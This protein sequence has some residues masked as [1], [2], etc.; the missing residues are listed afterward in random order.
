MTDWNNLA[1][2]PTIR[3]QDKKFRLWT[4]RRDRYAEMEKQPLRIVAHMVTPIIHAERDLTHLDSILSFAAL[5]NH[6]VESLHGPSG[7]SVIPLPLELLWVSPKG[8]P[9]WACTPLTPV[10]AAIE[11]KEYWHKRYPTHRAEFGSKMN[12]V[13][14]AGRWKEYRTPV[15]AQQ[16]D[17]LEAFCIGNADEIRRLLDVVTHVGKKGSM[18]YG[19]A[20]KWS[21]D[22]IDTGIDQILSARPVPIE[23]YE[24]KPV[25]GTVRL[26]RGF[27]P[28]YWYVPWW[29]DCVCP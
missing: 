7:V 21:V 15:M 29:A 9:L 13:T 12:A 28:P 18:G 16:V 6:P 22:A 24:P 20:A 26:N 3:W 8:L 27:T 17:L 19:R 11:S 10:G 4:T 5:T 14:S 1:P 23:Y 25:T 2:L